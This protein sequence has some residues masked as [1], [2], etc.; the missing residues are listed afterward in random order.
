M[1]ID[2]LRIHIKPLANKFTNL[3]KHQFQ[4]IEWRF[5]INSH[6]SLFFQIWKY[7]KQL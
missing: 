6:Y 7:T 1:L 5:D 4:V 2:E 3:F